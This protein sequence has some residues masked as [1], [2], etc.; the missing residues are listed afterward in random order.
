MSTFF[1]SPPCCSSQ[2]NITISWEWF[3]HI[4]IIHAAFSQVSTHC[5]LLISSKEVRPKKSTRE[6]LLTD[7]TLSKPTSFSILKPILHTYLAWK[8][9]TDL[10]RPFLHPSKIVPGVRRQDP[11]WPRRAFSGQNP[12]FSWSTENSNSRELLIGR[13]RD[14]PFHLYQRFLSQLQCH[15][16]L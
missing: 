7:S 12:N 9:T 1:H 5:H 15:S 10:M 4:I 6:D 13:K 14:D 3:S 16:I 2:N 8:K 11:E